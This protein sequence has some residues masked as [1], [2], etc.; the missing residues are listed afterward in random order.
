MNHIF[1][2][3]KVAP[4][5]YVVFPLL[6]TIR[7]KEDILIVAGSEEVALFFKNHTDFRV[8]SMQVHPNLIT[9]RTKYKLLHGPV[10][11]GFCS[12]CHEPHLSKMEHL[13][14]YNKQELCIYCH[15]FED[16]KRSRAHDG[17]KETNCLSCHDA[18]GGETNAYLVKKANESENKT[19][20]SVQE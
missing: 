1:F 13:L 18:H 8:I 17:I 5:Y 12:A 16:I 20:N 14:K 11:S 19:D 6:E 3:T 15:S 9:R 4:I 10:A 2:I 7:N